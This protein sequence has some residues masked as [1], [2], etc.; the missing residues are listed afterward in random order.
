MR[1]IIFRGKRVDNSG[2][3]YGSLA[4]NVY[5]A[6]YPIIIHSSEYNDGNNVDI[7]YDFVAPETIGQYTG[8]TDKNYTKIFEGDIVTLPK[9]GGGKTKSVVYF[10]DG[11]FAVDGSNYAFKDIR[12]QRMEV[13]GN[14][15]D[16]P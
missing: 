12:S 9:Y 1:E 10:K 4:T 15:Y 6:K 5:G 8:L 2:W 3:T 13:V 11:K 16:N 14:F 7:D